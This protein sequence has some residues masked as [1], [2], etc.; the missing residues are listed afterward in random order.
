MTRRRALGRPSRSGAGSGA[1]AA[2]ALSATLGEG[3]RLARGELGEPLAVELDAGG[4]EAAHE[5][6]VGEAV[7]ARGGVD[8]DDPQ[9]AEVALLALAA[10]VGV[11]ARLVGRLLR[12]L[13]ELAL[14]LEVALGELAELLAL[15]AANRSTFDARHDCSVRDWGPAFAGLGP[16]NLRTASVRNCPNRQCR[17]LGLGS[18]PE[19]RP[20]PRAEVPESLIATCTAASARSLRASAVGRRPLV[21]RMW[22]FRFVVLLVRMWRLNAAAAQ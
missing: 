22:R 21:P 9:A 16:R 14:V 4:L 1:P 7:L 3:R 12:E 17:R 15:V 2:L 11:D 20:E 18:A 5:H 10:D 8:A 13:V 6:A 19:T